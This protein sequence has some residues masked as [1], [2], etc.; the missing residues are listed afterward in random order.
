[1]RFVM[2]VTIPPEQ[3]SKAIL[4]GSIGQKM[5]RILEDMKPE[6][7]YFCA[8]EGKRGGFFIV[9]MEKVSE[10]VRFAEPWFLTFNAE[11]Q[12]MPTMSPQ[13]LQQAGLDEIGKKWR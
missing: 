10:M 11:V 7:A 13:D 5:N 1:M 8:V 3:F 4:D 12:Y 9:N 2:K 6:A